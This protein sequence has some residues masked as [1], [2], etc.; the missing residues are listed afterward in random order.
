[1]VAGVL[2]EMFLKERRLKNSVIEKNKKDA[3]KH[4]RIDGGCNHE[5]LK[6]ALKHTLNVF[7]FIALTTFI[8]GVTI[9]LIGEEKLAML[10]LSDSIFQPAV[11][12][13]LGLIPNCAASVMLTQLYISGSISFGSVISGLSTGAGIGLIVLFKINRNMLEN[14]K[15]ITYIYGFSTLVGILIQLFM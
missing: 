8:L 15:I 3:V 5:I 1:M 2:A 4:L 7:A 11:A 12:S 13:A 14:V 10:L 6:P 9:E